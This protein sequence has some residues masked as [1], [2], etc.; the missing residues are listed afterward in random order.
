VGSPCRDRHASTRRAASV[1]GSTR[2]SAVVPGGSAAGCLLRAG[3]PLA[4]CFECL[5]R[6]KW[7]YPN[8]NRCPPVPE[9][10][11][12]LVRRLGNQSF[13]G[14]LNGA[15][16]PARPGPPGSRYRS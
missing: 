13:L 6:E 7:S 14:V 9:E 16:D 10:F 4:G 12:Q 5:V 15:L 11:C 1:T 3:R 2:G 8:A